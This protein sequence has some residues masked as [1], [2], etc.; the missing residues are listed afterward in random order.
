VNPRRLSESEYTSRS[1]SVVPEITAV[2]N[3]NKND[4]N[5]AMIELVINI[6]PP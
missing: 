6:A 4:P 2:S 3:P 5:A 1:A